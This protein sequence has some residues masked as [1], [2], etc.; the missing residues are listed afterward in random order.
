[1]LE[2]EIK[3]KRTEVKAL[4]NGVK[5]SVRTGLSPSSPRSWQERLSET[6]KRKKEELEM[7]K[8]SLGGGGSITPRWFNAW[9]RG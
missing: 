7:L 2:V 8:V 4:E 9:V 3:V 6:E 5:Q 1:M